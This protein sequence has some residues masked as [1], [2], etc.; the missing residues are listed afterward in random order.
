MSIKSLGSW[1]TRVNLENSMAR[2][3]LTKGFKTRSKLLY[4]PVGWS[5]QTDTQD[6]L[7]LWGGHFSSLLN[8]SE[9]GKA[10]GSMLDFPI[11]VD[12]TNVSLPDYEKVQI[13]IA[14]S[15]THKTAGDDRRTDEV[16]ALVSLQYRYKSMTENWNLR[17]ICRDPT[18]CTSYR[19]I[20]FSISSVLDEG[21]IRFRKTGWY[22]KIYKNPTSWG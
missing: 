2:I 14:L 9:N 15:K 4:N 13:A 10:G 5:S 1:P 17:V 21:E 20:S 6:I 18:I 3:W 8:D 19:A 11:A 7:K 16:H 12:W 22:Y